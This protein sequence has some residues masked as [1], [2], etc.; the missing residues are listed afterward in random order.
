MPIAR[1]EVFGP[2]LVVMSYDSDEEAIAIA[3]DSDYGLSA[4]I[5]SN[6][7]ERALSTA[8][9]IQSGNVW[10]NNAHQI[11]CQVPF[12]G[13]KQSGLGRELGPNALD[14]YTQVK[15]V[16]LDLNNDPDAKPFGILLSHSD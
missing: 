1:E 13:Y 16:Q 14:S 15:T 2:V 6:D 11:N 5:W 7:N 8:A 10:I 3:N 12:G 4:S 9:R